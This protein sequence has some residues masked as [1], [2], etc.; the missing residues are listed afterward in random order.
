[1]LSGTEVLDSTTGIE[2]AVVAWTDV[3]LGATPVEE[4]HS[5]SPGM[6]QVSVTDERVPVVATNTEE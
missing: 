1:V 4:A 6:P 5:G 2:E 3:V